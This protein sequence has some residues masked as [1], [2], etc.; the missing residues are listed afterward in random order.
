MKKPL[1]PGWYLIF[2]GD[3]FVWY[4]CE[5]EALRQKMLAPCVRGPLWV[6]NPKMDHEINEKRMAS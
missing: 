6:T 4:D 5:E 1:Y 3:N 2:P